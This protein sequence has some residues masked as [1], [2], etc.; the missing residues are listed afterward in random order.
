[1]W[2]GGMWEAM[3]GDGRTEKGRRQDDDEQK[4]FDTGPSHVV[5]HHTTTP[6]QACLASEIGRD[7]AGSGWYDRTM[8]GH[9]AVVYI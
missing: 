3:G 6:A 1:M 8:R 9:G 2:V 7:R 5:P 4:R